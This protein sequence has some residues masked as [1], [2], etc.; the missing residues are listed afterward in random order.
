MKSV[1][2]AVNERQDLKLQLVA[3]GGIVLPRYGGIFEAKEFDGF[4]VDE[5]IHFLIEGENPIT[6]AKSTGLALIEFTTLFENLKPDV[7]IVI[8]DR[9]E[10]I[11]IA[12]AASYI[13]IPI[14][15]LEGGEVTGSID[16]S[17]RHAITKLAHL[18][19]PATKKAA[20]RI[21][22]L[23][24]SE[25]SV[26]V[27]GS[28]SIDVI[29]RSD[30]SSKVE[31]RKLQKEKGLMGA[32]PIIDLN[33]QYLVVIQH[34]VTTE[35]K[36]SLFQIEQTIQAIHELKIN[37]VW[38]WPNMD[39]GSDGT[40]KGI[41][42][43][44]EAHRPDYIHYF[45]SLPIEVFASLLNNSACIVGNSSCGI[46]EAEFLGVPCVNI[47]TR[48]SGRERGKNVLDVGYDKK[49]I[50]KA[51]IHQI[52]H[53]KYTPEFLY[54]DGK[55]AAKIVEILSTFDFKIQKKIAY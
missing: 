8:A 19:L 49:E 33:G 2:E 12:I 38:I 46:R 47:G 39:A 18:H 6:M 44:R 54:G 41:R 36:E 37:T 15:H 27:V 21:K 11:A 3:A 29:A 32:G 35:Y 24:E 17:T 53:G 45:K 30:L 4:K 55:S 9:F 14:A 23:G 16:E 51:I 48:Q 25:D 28:P 1:M 50:A 13:N 43:Y 34:P 5:I 26:F 7:V 22:K 52:K 40:S 31:L 10:S 20:E 42:E